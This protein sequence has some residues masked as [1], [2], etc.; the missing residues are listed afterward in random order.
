M[1]GF[2]EMGRSGA[3]PLQGTENE[4]GWTVGIIDSRVSRVLGEGDR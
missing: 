3:A 1:S 4:T 2:A